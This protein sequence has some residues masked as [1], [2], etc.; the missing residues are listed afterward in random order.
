M[1]YYTDG[2]VNSDF[3]QKLDA[4]RD[5]LTTNGRTLVQG[6]LGWIWGQSETYVPIPGAQTEEQ[7]EGISGAFTFGALP[8]EIMNEIESLI[9]RTPDEPD[10]SR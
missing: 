6:A 3:M 4:V 8:V 7:I 9:S 5:L 10:R 2:R 1:E